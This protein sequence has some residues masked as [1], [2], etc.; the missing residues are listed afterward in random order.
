VTVPT[1]E[2]Q[3]TFLS[4]VQRLL[5][6][7]VFVSTYKHALLMALL[8]L[9]VELGDDSG[10]PMRVPLD[11]IAERVIGY[12][13]R[14]IA[15]YAPAPGRGIPAVLAQNTGGPASILAHVRALREHSDERLAVARRDVA[16][17]SATVREVRRVLRVMPLWKLQV[18]GGTPLEFLYPH[19]L[20][21]DAIELLPGVAWSLRRFHGLLQGLVEAA[22]VRQVRRIRENQV[23][24][25]ERADLGEFLFGSERASLA[26]YRPVLRDAQ[27]G[28]CFYCR[29]PLH[30]A[31]EVDHFIPWSRYPVDLPHNFVLAHAQC[32]RAKR[33]FLGD[34]WHLEHWVERNATQGTALAREF[35]NI[36]VVHDLAA[37]R[38]VAWWSYAQAEQAGARVWLGEDELR[39]LS[40][41]WRQLLTC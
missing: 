8:D 13:W 11:A 19:R 10:R 21:G 35:D 27:A 1:A 39:R 25:G 5:D 36:R 7:G 17:W 31:G 23:L 22:W 40:P 18:V 9:A 26:E 2:E 41:G 34:L 6:E 28:A 33:D 24:L 12:Y 20:S 3:V 30:A 37:S 32:N 4:R 14:Q 16:R 38:H 29:R 15:P